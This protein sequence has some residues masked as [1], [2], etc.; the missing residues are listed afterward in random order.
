M[1]GVRSP[2]GARRG[3]PALTPFPANAGIPLPPAD[4]RHSRWWRAQCH[5]TAGGLVQEER[6]RGSLMAIGPQTVGRGI[7]M[8]PSD[9]AGQSVDVAGWACKTAGSGRRCGVPVETLAG[10]V[11]G[12]AIADWT[13][14]TGNPQARSH[15][16]GMWTTAAMKQTSDGND[17][18]HRATGGNYPTLSKP[19]FGWSLVSILG[20]HPFPG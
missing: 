18:K 19:I 4:N 1:I 2:A 11:M 16:S 7:T 8:P 6:D 14:G 9:T 13:P 10:N 15:A 3:R 17:S 5:K 20:S 12:D